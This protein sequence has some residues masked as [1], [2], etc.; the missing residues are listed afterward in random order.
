MQSSRTETDAPRVVIVGRTN[1]GKSTLFNRL[2]LKRRAIT[3]PTPGVTR[4]PVEAR[5]RLSGREATLV[6]TGGFSLDPDDLQRLVHRKTLDW[7][8]TAI[9]SCS[10]STSTRRRRRT[11]NS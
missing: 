10:W 11:R 3:D 1:T 4:D 9:S 8:G 7:L 5:C 2:L 6:D